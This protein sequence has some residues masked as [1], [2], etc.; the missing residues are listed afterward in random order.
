MD[1]AKKTRFCGNCR[2]HNPYE[3]PIMIF[4]VKRYGQNKDPIM[5]TLEC[6]NNWSPVNQSCHCVRDA[7]KKINSE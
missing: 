7:L 6:C 2:S 5:D 3:Y 4:C 1:I